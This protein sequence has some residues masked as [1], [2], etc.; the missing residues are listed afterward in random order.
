MKCA[1][2]VF[3]NSENSAGES[4]TRRI[5]ELSVPRSQLL[6]TDSASADIIPLQ[7]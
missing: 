5:S 4:E 3:F 1:A 6:E 2:P 7:Q